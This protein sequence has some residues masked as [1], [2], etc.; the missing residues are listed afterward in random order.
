MKSKAT[1]F[2]STSTVFPSLVLLCVSSI[3]I[4]IIIMIIII[5]IAVVVIIIVI[6]K[7][8]IVIIIIKI[9]TI[10]NYPKLSKKELS[11]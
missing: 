6:V 5:I 7:V 8:I 1:S 9:I 3:M 11:K 4:M 10:K 2:G